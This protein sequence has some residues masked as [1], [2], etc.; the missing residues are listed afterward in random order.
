[1][2]AERAVAS[3]LAQLISFRDAT[4]SL[5]KRGCRRKISSHMGLSDGS[6]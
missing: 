5:Y 4:A 1:M 2:G 3:S 6:D